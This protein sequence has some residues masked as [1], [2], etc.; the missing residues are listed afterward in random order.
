MQ[1]DRKTTVIIGTSLI[2]I[3]IVMA[4]GLWGLLPVLG[5]S[6]AGAYLYTER[7]RAGGLAQL[8][9]AGCG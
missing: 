1:M 5:L 6:A 8:C 3:G 4:F 7:R 9:R 2:V